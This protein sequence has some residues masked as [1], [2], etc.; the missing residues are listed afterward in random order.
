MIQLPSWTVKIKFPLTR[1]YLTIEGER[2][3]DVNG[4]L[5]PNTSQHRGALAFRG[6]GSR[7]G[8]TRGGHGGSGGGHGGFR[9]GNGGRGGHGGV[10]DGLRLW[11]SLWQIFPTQSLV[12]QR[13]VAYQER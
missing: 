5:A 12:Q 13:I 11:H 4:D 2:V 10:G 9:G 1:V 3:G 7:G 6:G 8:L